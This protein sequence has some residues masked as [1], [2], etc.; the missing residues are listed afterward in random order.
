[1]TAASVPFNFEKEGQAL[2]EGRQADLENRQPL[3][4]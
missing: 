3:S 1:M 4:R 2:L